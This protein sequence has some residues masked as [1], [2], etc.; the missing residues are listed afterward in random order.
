MD[1]PASRDKKL[2]LTYNGFKRV[3][4]VMEIGALVPFKF[5]EGRTVSLD[6]RAD[7][8]KQILRI[9]NYNAQHSL[10]KPKPRSVTG[11]LSRQDTVSSSVEAFEAV[12]EEIPP[13][14][15]FKVD[16][17][18]IG[19]S[20]VNKKLTEVIYLLMDKL[21]FEYTAS[22]TA[23]AFNLSCGT[24][25]VDNQLH[26]GLFPVI[27]QPTP[28]P[29]ESNTVAALPTVQASVIL[30]NDEAHGVLFVKYCSVLLQALTIEAD[31]DLLFAIYDL[32]QIKGASW[33]EGTK[34]I[35][36]ESTEI[37]EPKDTAAGQDIYFE[38]LE[39]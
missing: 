6:V 7:G 37:P 35:L 9:T 27:L 18:G 29:K 17:A 30:L 23:R 28:V 15:G 8:R 31:E 26:D 3:V 25:Q 24:L 36:I 20:L 38:V 5:N 13:T 16:F 10:Y 1:F 4:N 22:P 12:T 11:S 34:D 14:F 39:L 33:E 32:T 21:S 2:W 19:I